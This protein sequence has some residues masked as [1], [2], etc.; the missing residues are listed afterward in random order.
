MSR[1]VFL[2][3]PGDPFL[4]N[5]WLNLFDNVWGSEVDILYIYMNSPIEMDVVEYCRKRAQASPHNVVF[6]WH[7]EQKEHGWVLNEIL[8]QC[9]ETHIL[10]CEDDGFIFRPGVVDRA[11][12]MLESGNFDIVGSKRGSCSQ[13]IL[14]KAKQRFG[15]SYEGLG[16][17]GC[18]FWPCFFFTSRRLL[19]Q[20]DR[21]FGARAW[22]RGELVQ[23]LDY[24]TDVEIVVGD[25]FVNTSLQLHAMVPEDRILYLPQYHGHPDDMMHYQQ[26]TGIFD[27]NAGWCHIGSLSTGVGG[28]LMD[29]EGRP[30]TRRLIDPPNPDKGKFL[31]RPTTDFEKREYERRVQWWLRFWQKRQFGEIEGFADLYVQAINRIIAGFDLSSFAIE[32][33]QRIYR[34]AFSL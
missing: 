12:K 18:N 9:K 33:R 20:T 26:H 7:N 23:P 5:Y 32:E 34:E 25:T 19:L 24:I 22:K 30:L 6:M 2:P 16:D 10:L 17:Q 3:F 14:D 4:L 29:D 13:E 21:N 1:A 15:L 11:F 31:N 27:C 28:I 8:E